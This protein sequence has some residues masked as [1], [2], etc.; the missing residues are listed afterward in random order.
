MRSKLKDTIEDKIAPLEET[1]T[2]VPAI[3]LDDVVGF[4][5]DPEIEANQSDS[6]QPPRIW[7]LNES[8]ALT[9]ISTYLMTWVP[10]D[11]PSGIRKQENANMQ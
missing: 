2:P 7:R 8:A 9:E 11:R 1:V 6:S 3:V 4:G 5:L 10:K